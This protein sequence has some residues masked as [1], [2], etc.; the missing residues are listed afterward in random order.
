MELPWRIKKMGDNREEQL[1]WKQLW[2]GML[3][4]PKQHK[5]SKSYLDCEQVGQQHKILQIPNFLKA[6]TSQTS[7]LA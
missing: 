7:S 3:E 2:H 5:K 6:F 1:H 4:E